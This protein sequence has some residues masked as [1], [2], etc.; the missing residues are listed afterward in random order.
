MLYSETEPESYI[1]EYTLAYETQK[2]SSDVN[3][4]R[5]TETR[6]RGGHPAFDSPL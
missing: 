2:G 1:T 3:P 4:E 6:G 5:Y